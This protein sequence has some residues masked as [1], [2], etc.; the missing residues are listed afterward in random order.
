MP[1]LDNFLD[2]LTKKRSVA[3]KDKSQSKE[4]IIHHHKISYVSAKKYFKNLTKKPGRQGEIYLSPK[5]ANIAR[6][7]DQGLAVLKKP[8]FDTQWSAPMADLLWKW[9]EKPLN[10]FLL[11]P[12]DIW[13]TMSKDNVYFPIAASQGP[14]GDRDILTFYLLHIV[15]WIPIFWYYFNNCICPSQFSVLFGFFFG[16]IMF[17]TID[18]LNNNNTDLLV[19]KFRRKWN[20]SSSESQP[21]D[22][23]IIK[24]RHDTKK[25]KSISYLYEP[26]KFKEM[27][28]KKNLNLLP[29]KD[30]YTNRG[31]ADFKGKTLRELGHSH[32]SISNAGYYIISSVVTVGIVT[33]KAS[34]RHFKLITPLILLISFIVICGLY[35]WEWGYNSAQNYNLL[36]REKKIIVESISI[37]LTLVLI[38]LNCKFFKHHDYSYDKIFI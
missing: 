30:W 38:V 19:D 4:E 7:K 17:M 3:H 18:I 9:V 22:M 11:P 34:L 16:L 23:T 15:I 8:Y 29:L 2:Q 28:I 36:N 1:D 24:D 6:G 21:D 25:D 10:Y 33:A 26:K 12:K 35:G 37:S 27:A 14:F 31:D 32:Q 5:N 20:Y 13:W